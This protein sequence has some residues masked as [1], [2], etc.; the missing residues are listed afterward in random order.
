MDDAIERTERMRQRVRDQVLARLAWPWRFEEYP[1][2]KLAE[3]PGEAELEVLMWEL[4]LRDRE[5]LQRA[6]EP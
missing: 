3:P 5:T 4:D 6:E 1:L 2:A